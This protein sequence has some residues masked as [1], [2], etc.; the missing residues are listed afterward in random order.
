MGHKWGKKIFLLFLITKS[1][2]VFPCLCFRRQIRPITSAIQ[3]FHT[4][5]LLQQ[6]LHLWAHVSRIRNDQKWLC[7]LARNACFILKT[8]YQSL[9]HFWKP[10]I[11]EP[12]SWFSNYWK[13]MWTKYFIHHGPQCHQLFPTENGFSPFSLG[14]SFSEQGTFAQE[15]GEALLWCKKSANAARWAASSHESLSQTTNLFTRIWCSINVARILYEGQCYCVQLARRSKKIAAKMLQF[16]LDLFEENTLSFLEYTHAGRFSGLLTCT[17]T[18][19]SSGSQ[20]HAAVIGSQVCLSLIVCDRASLRVMSR[21]ECCRQSTKLIRLWGCILHG[22]GGTRRKLMPLPIP[23][24]NTRKHSRVRNKKRQ[25]LQK[26]DLHCFL[27]MQAIIT[28]GKPFWMCVEFLEAVVPFQLTCRQIHLAARKSS[29]LFRS[30]NNCGNVASFH[31]RSTLRI[32]PR[33]KISVPASDT[34][35]PFSLVHVCCKFYLNKP[36]H[37]IHDTMVSDLWCS[38]WF[39]IQ[40]RRSEDNYPYQNRFLR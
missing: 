4:W 11:R 26:R 16:Y 6:K 32:C 10:I 21:R 7:T 40:R 25:C 23:L 27:A 13:S 8:D 35:V 14:P 9:F 28:C 5:R 30:S 12:A 15:P 37:W 18:I 24:S 1:L 38:S 22:N 36:F 39:P 29:H 20:K 2:V 19:A 34:C 31:A 33:C 3:R 17:F